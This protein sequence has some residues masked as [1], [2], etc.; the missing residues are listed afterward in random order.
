MAKQPGANA[1][2]PET[3][4][5]GAREKQR[6][7]SCGGSNAELSWQ[8]A[9]NNR[10]FCKDPLCGGIAYSGSWSLYRTQL[11]IYLVATC[12]NRRCP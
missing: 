5:D 12:S 10:L 8:F 1:Q 9:N 2:H 7:P 11:R 6:P 4:T 3:Y